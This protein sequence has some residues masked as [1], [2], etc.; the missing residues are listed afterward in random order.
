MRVAMAFP[1]APVA[2]VTR[3]TR[4][5]FWCLVS[6]FIFVMMGSFRLLSNLFQSDLG[7][8]RQ[9]LTERDGVVVDRVAG[10][11]QQG[12]PTAT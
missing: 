6:S 8:S 2:P 3:A 9:V 1:I 4:R 5:E 11:E 12:Q 7:C 10:G